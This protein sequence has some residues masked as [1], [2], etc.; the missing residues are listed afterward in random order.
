VKHP[1]SSAEEDLSISVLRWAMLAVNSTEDNR[2][3]NV[4]QG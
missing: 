3:A 4:E 2:Q 1:S